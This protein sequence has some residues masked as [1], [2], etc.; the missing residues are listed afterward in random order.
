MKIHHIRTL[1]YLVGIYLLAGLLLTACA[2]DT[3]NYIP[4]VESGVAVKVS[5]EIKIPTVISP[6]SSSS[7]VK[8]SMTAP[9]GN[10]F[11]VSL[12]S[13]VMSLAQAD[14]ATIT[15]VGGTRKLYNLWVFQFAA[16]GTRRKVTKMPNSPEPIRDHV[17]IDVELITGSDQTI[18]LVALGSE[19]SSIDLSAIGTKDELEAYTLPA[20]K[21][22]AQGN[23]IPVITSDEQMPYC[24]SYNGLTI[25]QDANGRGYLRYPDNIPFTGGISLTAMLARV[26]LDFSFQVEQAEVGSMTLNNFPSTYPIKP[27]SSYKPTDFVNMGVKLDAPS[28]ITSDGRYQ[29]KWYVAPNPQGKVASITSQEKRVRAN[30]YFDAVNPG[31]LIGDAPE[32]GTHIVIWAKHKTE[33]RY[34]L[35]YLFLG[36]NLTDDFNVLPGSA[37]IMRT[38]INAIDTPDDLRIISSPMSQ[39]LYFRSSETKGT[40]DANWLKINGDNNFGSD[41][42]DLDAHPSMRPIEIFVLSGDVKI[43]LTKGSNW[44][45][46]SAYPNYTAAKQAELAGKPDGLASSISVRAE[47]PTRYKFYVYCDEYDKY[48]HSDVTTNKRS[49]ELRFDIA[50]I[51]GTGTKTVF[52]TID[53]RP[54]FIAGRVGGDFDINTGTYSEYLAYESISEYDDG[55]HNTVNFPCDYLPY[56]PKNAW[57]DRGFYVTKDWNTAKANYDVGNF[58]NGKKATRLMAEGKSGEDMYS[59]YTAKPTWTGGKLDLYQYDYTA[60]VS[61]SSKEGHGFVARACFDKNR[62]DNGNGV[63]DPEEYHWYM[64]SFA[65]HHIGATFNY[66]AGYTNAN[67]NIYLKA[68]LNRDA[69]TTT[70][71]SQTEWFNL[72]VKNLAFPNFNSGFSPLCVRDLPTTT[73]NVS[74][75]PEQPKIEIYN[76]GVANYAAIDATNLKTNSFPRFSSQ[77][78]NVVHDDKTVAGINKDKYI[79]TST[80]AGIRTI[81]HKIAT[82]AFAY[83]EQYAAFVVSNKFMIAN[84]N[85]PATNSWAV[86]SGWSNAANSNLSGNTTAVT[87]CAAYKGTNGSEAEGTWRVPNIYE[88]VLISIYD[89]ALQTTTATTGYKSLENNTSGNAMFWSSTETATNTAVSFRPMVHN[90]TTSPGSRSS[91]KT[92][93]YYV[94]CIK[95][96]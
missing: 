25:A 68:S 70:Q 19:Y 4:P 58:Y 76:D 33:S 59:D 11:S 67:Y 89:G 91:T 27:S 31:Q 43:R 46:L 30:N 92:N 26:E 49:G 53:Q 15:R 5:L 39:T 62:D 37:Y 13:D 48:I 40:T 14:T 66:R 38:D 94:R 95:D 83:H 52:T 1:P 72:A 57:L 56:Y 3:L 82:L 71:Y 22:D 51:D 35:Y 78:T 34:V 8:Q 79:F 90:G 12:M 21:S 10:G 75:S 6:A 36:G 23:S 16:D 29:F 45:H 7:V 77:Y 85:I 65:Q 24:G 81:R 61:P 55:I 96:Y 50:T 84:E 18:Y 60:L 54:A 63:I 73:P 17:L 47:I 41:K 86:V 74:S 87:G 32:K 93:N 69:A 64:P 80:T 88:L 2:K 28:L 44:L 20:T 42:Y 9:Q